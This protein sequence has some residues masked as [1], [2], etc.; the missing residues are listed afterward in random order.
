[1]SRKQDQ[2][3]NSLDGAKRPRLSPL[4]RMVQ[5][6]QPLVGGGSHWGMV[7]PAPYWRAMSTLASLGAMVTFKMAGNNYL[8][9]ASVWHAGV[10]VE[11]STPEPTEVLAWLEEAVALLGLREEK[12]DSV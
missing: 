11:K 7:D 5:G 1:M 12:N 3:G 4:S 6:A 9:S 10:R 2:H 8:Y